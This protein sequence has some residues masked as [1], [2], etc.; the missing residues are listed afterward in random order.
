MKIEEMVEAWTNYLHLDKS[1]QQYAAGLIKGFS[2]ASELKKE[3][4][5]EE[6]E[7]ETT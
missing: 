3:T 2:L 4:R 1:K 7:H 6:E 5:K